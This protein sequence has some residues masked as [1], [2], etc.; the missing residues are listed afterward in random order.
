MIVHA[1]QSS[2]HDIVMTSQHSLPEKAPWLSSYFH[3]CVRVERAS[4]IVHK[5]LSQA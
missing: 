3:N 1:I 5:L 4:R 2:T